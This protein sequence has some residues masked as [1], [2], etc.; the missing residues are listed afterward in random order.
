MKQ[1]KDIKLIS[2]DEVLK[3][4]RLKNEPYRFKG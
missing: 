4:F 1:N 3:W 2:F